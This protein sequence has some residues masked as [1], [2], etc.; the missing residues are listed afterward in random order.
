MSARYFAQDNSFTDWPGIGEAEFIGLRNFEEMFFEDQS[1]LDALSRNIQWMLF[2]ITVPFVFALFG[3]SLLAKVRRG[4]MIYRTAL[5]M[6]FIL[7]SVV[8][9]TIWRYLY[10]PRFGLPVELEGAA[11]VDGANEL[12][13]L[14]RI[15]VPLAWPGFLTVGLLVGLGIWSELQVALIFVHKPNMFPV[16]TSYIK[17]IDRFC[18]DWAMTSAGAFMM[19]APVLI[20]FLE[21]Q[22]L[23]VEGLTQGGVKV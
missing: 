2:F 17:F 14:L 12:Q 6:P 10:N 19:I 4:A 16:T 18:R 3:S 23:F 15:I 22:R 8:T 20:L 13:V 7:P 1:H 21:L 5:F 9:A 11:R